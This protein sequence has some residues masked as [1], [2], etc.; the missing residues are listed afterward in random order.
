MGA[1]ELVD[2][3]P[4]TLNARFPNSPKPRVVMTDRGPAFYQAST[5]RITDEYRGALAQHGLRPLLGG[6][7]RCR[8][9]A[10]KT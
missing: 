10:R 6:L 1:H 7:L 2:K 5:C 3:L 4:A 8:Q 9:G